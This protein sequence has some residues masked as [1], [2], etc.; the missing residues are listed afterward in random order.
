[1]VESPRPD[2]GE[3]PAS[4]TERGYSTAEDRFGELPRRHTERWFEANI[5]RSRALG[6]ERG[7]REERQP[8]GAI[9]STGEHA[10][11]SVPESVGTES[12]GRLRID[13][14]TCPLRRPLHS[15]ARMAPS[16]GLFSLGSTWHHYRPCG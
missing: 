10:A 9:A 14:L 11:K 16:L 3:G 2:S 13:T 4:A 5:L 1:M 15:R 8:P 7:P 6:L 12:S